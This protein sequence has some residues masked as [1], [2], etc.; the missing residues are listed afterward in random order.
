MLPSDPPSSYTY[1]YFSPE[2][3][4]EFVSIFRTMFPHPNVPDEAYEQV[5]RKLD[6]KAA[7]DQA[8]AVLLSDGVGALNSETGRKWGMLSEQTK[9]EALRR[10][11][12]TAFFKP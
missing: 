3:A 4:Q 12:G 1:R 8:L 7:K 5:V 9:T 11:E 6:E 10:A 2:L